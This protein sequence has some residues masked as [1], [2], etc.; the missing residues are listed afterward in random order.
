MNKIIILAITENIAGREVV[1]VLGLV[2]GSTI[3]VRHIGS[4]IVSASRSLFGDEVNSYVIALNEARNGASERM[5]QEA[6]DLDTEAVICMKYS[7]S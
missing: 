2:K 6:R 5:L 3:R 1:Q 7:T 4:D